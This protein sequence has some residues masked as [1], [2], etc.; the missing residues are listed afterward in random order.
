MPAKL[1]NEQRHALAQHP[2]APLEVEDPETH[3]KYVIVEL[4]VFEQM[5]TLLSYDDSEP[6]PR[7]FYGAFRAAVKDDLVRCPLA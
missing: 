6:D 1:S 4:D 5:R 2:G 3:G 7:D